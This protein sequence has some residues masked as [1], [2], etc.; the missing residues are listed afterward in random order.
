MR[1][2]VILRSGLVFDG[3]GAPGR[4]ADVGIRDGKVA[5]IEE[6]LDPALG[7]HVVDAT[8]QWVMP[9]FLDAHT[10][11]D[12]ELL[13]APGLP[14]SVRHGV[15]TV[16]IGS[17]SLSTIYSTPEDCADIFARVEA[18]PREY[19]LDALEEHKTWSDPAAYMAHVDALPLGPNVMSFIGHSDLRVSVMGLED[20]T[21][22]K[23]VPTAEEQERMETALREAIDLG[24]LGLSC[25]TN[26]WDKIGGDRVRSRPLPSTFATWKEYRRFHSIL[27]E[28]G[29]IL[30]SAPNITTKYNAALYL[31]DSAGFGVRKPLKTT[32]ITVADTKSNPM[33]ASAILRGTSVFN[34]ALGAD[35]RWQCVPMPFEVYADGID[36][37]VFEEFGAGEEALHLTE[38]VERNAL[39]ADKAY[40][41]RF[42]K[43]YDKRFGPRVWHRDLHDAH[44][45][46]A[47]DPTLAGRSFGEVADERKEHPV[48]TFLD[49]VME[50]GTALRWR[51][52]IANHRKKQLDEIVSH[53]T[54]QV[55][56][57]DSGAHI[58]NMAFYNFPLYFLRS[59][60]RAAEAGA[61][62]MSLERA[63]HRVTGEIGDWLGVDA[64]HLRVGSRADVVVV[65]PAGLN[66]DIEAYHEAPIEVF[67]GVRRM[68]R[69]NDDAITATL[70]GGRVVYTPAGFVDGYGTTQGFGRFLKRGQ[71]VAPRAVSATATEAAEQPLSAQA[72]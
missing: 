25:M 41:R 5:A 56:F 27:R 35:I 33:L 70:I 20:A 10:H 8:G 21:D 23:R 7:D 44:I 12:A 24:F 48:D 13:L 32:L 62:I 18:L 66:D 6:S 57:A 59:V 14:E 52:T 15:T 1:Y 39:F 17:C 34:D 31:W 2:D 4:L 50:H 64:G 16:C 68:V 65:N 58:R 42:R 19:V 60:K 67:G 9:G 53:P 29:A 55:G 30:Q 72:S 46:S 47:P 71:S 61:P 63:V 37:V 54:V 45:V 3:S 26:P 51:T 38:Q 36:L 11:Y 69:R 22:S 28:R 43:E 49:L 40:R